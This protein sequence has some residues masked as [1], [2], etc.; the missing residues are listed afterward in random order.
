MLEKLYQ[1]QITLQQAR[2]IF[3]NLR[4]AADSNKTLQVKL[5]KEKFL[6]NMFSPGI[7]RRIF[8]GQKDLMLSDTFYIRTNGERAAGPWDESKMFA[9]AIV[10]KTSRVT[11]VPEVAVARYTLI[12]R[13][14]D[15]RRPLGF[16]AVATAGVLWELYGRDWESGSW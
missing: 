1:K 3:A 5:L 14:Y 7:Y 6:E 2:L 11:V 13:L 15:N 4:G 12:E 16:L 9:A 8:K 10:E